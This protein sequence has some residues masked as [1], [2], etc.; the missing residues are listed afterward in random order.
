MKSVR[1]FGIHLF[2]TCDKITNLIPDLVMTLKL[3]IGG[4]TDDPEGEGIFSS[5]PTP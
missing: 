5:K 3:F 1:L 2:Q 4:L